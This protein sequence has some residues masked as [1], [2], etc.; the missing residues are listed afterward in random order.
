VR[1]EVEVQQGM[2]RI[3]G[4][5]WGFYAYPRRPRHTPLPG[6]YSEAIELPG[7]ASLSTNAPLP[8]AVRL[9]ITRE[10]KRTRHDA[11]L[12]EGNCAVLL[13]GTGGYKET[14]AGYFLNQ[15]VRLRRHHRGP[16]CVRC[17]SA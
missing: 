6:V 2:Q 14:R 15:W 5:E 9:L 10:L 3:T 11:L 4:N 1:L 13:L 12:R 7:A 16:S 17:D 8:S